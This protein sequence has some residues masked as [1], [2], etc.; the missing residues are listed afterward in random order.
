MRHKVIKEFHIKPESNGFKFLF[1][2][3][4]FKD[5]NSLLVKTEEEFFSNTLLTKAA[6]NG[7]VSY[8]V[9]EKI[10]NGADYK[11]PNVPVTQKAKKNTSV[12]TVSTNKEPTDNEVP[13]NTVNEK[14]S[15]SV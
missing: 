9:V 12:A 10:V 15:E 5:R 4:G 2:Q 3:L 1:E 8:T 13:L 6:N 7:L 14:D 11:Q